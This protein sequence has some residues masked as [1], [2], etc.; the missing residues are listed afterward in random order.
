MDLINQIMSQQ[1]VP[2]RPAPGNQNVF[3]WLA[4]EFGNLLV[5]ASAHLTIR[6]SGQ[7]PVNVSETTMVGKDS[8]AWLISRCPGVHFSEVGSLATSG[9]KLLNN[10]KE[11]RPTRV[12]SAARSRSAVY[13]SKTP[14]ITGNRTETSLSGPV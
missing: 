1:I 6:T 11:T 3:A 8:P 2:E 10:W 7:F 4:F 12:M 5:S 14:P 9:Q 13:V